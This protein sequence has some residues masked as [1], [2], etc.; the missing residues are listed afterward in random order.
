[1]LEIFGTNQFPDP[2]IATFLSDIVAN[3]IFLLISKEETVVVL[4]NKQQLIKCPPKI[5]AE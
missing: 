5:M 3:E 4:E 2:T 1:M